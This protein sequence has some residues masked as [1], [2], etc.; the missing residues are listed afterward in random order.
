[1]KS[2]QLLVV[3][4]PGDAPAS[5]QLAV[6]AEA[7]EPPLTAVPPLAAGLEAAL[8]AVAGADAPA[9]GAVGEGAAKSAASTPAPAVLS[10][11][12]RSCRNGSCGSV[13]EH[14]LGAIATPRNEFTRGPP[15]VKVSDGALARR[16]QTMLL[17][18]LAVASEVAYSSPYV[19][20]KRRVLT[21]L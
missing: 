20:A 2:A 15:E 18:E 1:V 4:P 14:V 11:V 3:W 16:Y 5:A 6:S 7:E 17:A 19:A 21:G 8:A 9:A 10:P 12:S 13:A